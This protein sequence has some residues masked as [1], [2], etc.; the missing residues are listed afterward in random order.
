MRIYHGYWKNQTI[1]FDHPY[2]KKYNYTKMKNIII[3][4]IPRKQKY[5]HQKVFVFF[6]LQ[7]SELW[8]LKVSA[9]KTDK[10]LKTLNKKFIIGII[11]TIKVY[12]YKFERNLTLVLLY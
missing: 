8:D 1:I 10:S 7:S 5:E 3:P 4:R 12:K 11:N 6:I 9:N 2:I